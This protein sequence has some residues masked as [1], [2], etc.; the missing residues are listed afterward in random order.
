MRERSCSCGGGKLDFWNLSSSLI[1]NGNT[2]VLANDV[3]TLA[4][5]IAANPYGFFALASDYD[6]KADRRYK[7]SPIYVL[8]GSLNGLGHTIANLKIAS[9]EGCAGFISYLV[10]G[11]APCVANLTL[12]GDR[13]LPTAGGQ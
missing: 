1:V 11:T 9:G 4:S 12:V 7:T 10:T 5:A 6:A 13:S 8:Y 3:S 2:Y